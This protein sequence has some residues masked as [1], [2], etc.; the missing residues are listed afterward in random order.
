VYNPRVSQLIDYFTRVTPG[1]ALGLLLLWLL[2]RALAGARLCVHIGLFILVRDTMT[3]LGLW[4]IGEEPAPWLRLASDPVVLI[5]LAVAS[6]GLVIGTKQL[7]PS[8]ARTLVWWQGSKA[9]AAAAGVGC[10]LLIALPVI[11]LAH[12]VP[13][14]AR[15]GAVATSA[16]L[17]LLIFSLCGN[18][19]EE[20]LFRGFL[21]GWL[22][23]HTTAVRAMV[24][25]GLA[26]AFGHIYLATTVTG[27]GVAVLAFT[28][29]EGLICAELRR[30]MGLWSAVLAHGGG[31][32][33]LA[34]GLPG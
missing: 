2:P 31:I 1:F 25:T 9:L 18:A 12:G 32:F 27:V 20:L 7:E 29:Y 30:R 19:Y 6:L 16:L 5:A 21:Q 23:E 13:I 14:G 24:L 17:P 33:I 15:G 26:F 34:T 28:A 4:R 11:A 10:A 3:P 22:M 8:L